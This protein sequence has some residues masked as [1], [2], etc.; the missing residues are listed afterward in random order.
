MIITAAL[1]LNF[2]AQ[3]ESAAGTPRKHVFERALKHGAGSVVVFLLGIIVIWPVGALLSYHMRLLLL[4]ITTI[5]Q[6]RNQA[7]ISLVPGPAP[8]N[9]FSHGSW[10]KN[11]LQVLCRPVGHS[12]LDAHGYATQDEREVNPGFTGGAGKERQ[13]MS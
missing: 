2:L 9:P 8:P 6:I 1:H 11:L 13:V 12:W 4:N 5:E 3:R 7:H 10:R